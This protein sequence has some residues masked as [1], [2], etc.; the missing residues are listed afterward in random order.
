VTVPA[1]TISVLAFHSA[2][3]I[4]GCIRSCFALEHDGP[5]VVDVREQGGQVDEEALLQGL[6]AELDG[7]MG[8]RLH[9]EQGC[10]LGYAGGHNRA[11]RRSSSEFFLPLNADAH[12]AQDFLSEALPAFDDPSVGA[13]QGK[14]LREDASPRTIDTAG[15][16][17]LRNRAVVNRGQ[18]QP[19]VGQFDGPEEIFGPDGAAPL[20]R[21]A[22][23][24]DVA[25]PSPSP[26]GD[27]EY[28]DETFFAYKEDV[29]LAWRLQWRG[30]RTRYVPTA[31]AWHR[32]TAR[33][34]QQGLRRTLRERFDQP[35]S[36][37]RKGFVNH[38]L[39]QVKNEDVRALRRD[40]R[41]FLA[42][43]L[44]AWAFALVTDPGIVGS[45]AGFRRALTD[46]RRKRAWIQSRRSPT[47]DPYR[48]FSE[49][50][51]PSGLYRG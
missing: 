1:L 48:W 28:F 15:L 38:R 19:D 20:Y 21:R 44:S 4:E 11:L 37:R 9:V 22:A 45:V 7:A 34:S 2:A 50:G 42:R 14:V 43:E 30:W 39:M 12:L 10:N 33:G 25:V 6:A 8:R 49:G 23:L 13:V 32:R 5:L 47:A 17:P 27:P 31:V 46:A 40:M 35:T 18:G 29:D 16:L 3:T 41:P 24:D 51:P 36:I 26:E